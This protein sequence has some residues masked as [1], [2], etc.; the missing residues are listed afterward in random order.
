MIERF[1]ALINKGTTGFYLGAVWMA[2][3]FVLCPIISTKFLPQKISKWYED[4]PADKKLDWDARVGASLHSAIVFVITF[5]A[6]FFEEG[7]TYT[8]LQSHSDLVSNTLDFSLGYF[9]SDIIVCFCLR[10]YYGG[11][12]YMYY[13]HHV[14]CIVG[15]TQAKWD[16]AM[17]LVSFR[18]LSELSTPF[19]NINFMLELCKL[20]DSQIYKVN[21]EVIFW[22]FLACRPACIPIFYYFSWH[23]IKSG[24]FWNCPGEMI[25]V[26]IVCGL[27]L[28]TLNTVWFKLML[29][30]Y[31]QRK[32]QKT[33]NPSKRKNQPKRSAAT[34]S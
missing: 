1:Q 15:L 8:N 26:W 12:T 24:E 3:T 18:L 6:I 17:W 13:L 9:W 16:G 28:D 23:H 10:N 21:Q 32:R 11:I 14:V 2:F 19:M 20:K 22:T 29:T 25:F 34:G 31:I 5:Y 27:A 4:Q 7:Y 33:S 30:E